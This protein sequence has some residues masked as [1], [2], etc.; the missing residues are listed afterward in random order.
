MAE[1]QVPSTD[2]EI[3]EKAATPASAELVP[4]GMAMIDPTPELVAQVRAAILDGELP[5]EI[6]DPNIVA[7]AIRARI[8]DGSF[9][10]ALAPAQQLAGWRDAYLD[11]DVTVF[12]FHLN[13]SSKGDADGSGIAA[14]AVVELMVT[15]T[16]EID[17]VQT[18]GGNVLAQLVKAWEARAF[19]FRCRMIAKPTGTAGRSTFWLERI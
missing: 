14:Y 18:G 9:E 5:P 7:R 6:G 13:R 4:A 8:L 12:G 15:D 19:P 10:E 2:L 1:T 11:E 17:T 3:V 16:G